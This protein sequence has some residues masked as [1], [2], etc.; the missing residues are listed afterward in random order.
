MEEPIAE[1]AVQDDIEF[2]REQ[3]PRKSHKKGKKSQVK[4]ETVKSTITAIYELYNQEKL[5]EVDALLVKYRGKE[6][7]LLAALVKKYGP[8]PRPPLLILIKRFHPPKVEK[9]WSLQHFHGYV[10]ESLND[11]WDELE[12]IADSAGALGW[13]GEIVFN[14]E[15]HGGVS[16]ILLQLQVTHLDVGECVPDGVV[17]SLRMLVH[18]RHNG[19]GSGGGG[20]RGASTGGRGGR[21]G[22]KTWS[23]RGGAGKGAKSR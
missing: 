14:T 9:Q 3:T 19:R 1:D 11:I 12:A 16:N 5:N 21:G 4:E 15:Q 23:E 18:N 8:E 13:R 2:V 20:S 22:G 10:S 7:Q 17:E 6:T